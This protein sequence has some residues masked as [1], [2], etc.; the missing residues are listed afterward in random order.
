LTVLGEKLTPQ[1]V[2]LAGVRVIEE[3]LELAD[4]S[5]PITTINGL[6]VIAGYG[7]RILSIVIVMLATALFIRIAFV[8]V[9][10]FDDTPKL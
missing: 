3:L 5:V 10:L 1:D 7:L 4:T 8:I 2:K 9:I 6:V